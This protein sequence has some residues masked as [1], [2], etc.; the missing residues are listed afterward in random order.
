VFPKVRSTDHFWSARF[1]ILVRKKKP[2]YISQQKFFKRVLKSIF[3]THLII[4]VNLSLYY[5][6]AELCF[7]G[8]GVPQHFFRVFWSASSKSLGNT[9]LNKHVWRARIC[10]F[11]LYRADL[12]YIHKTVLKEGLPS[13]GKVC[14][15][16]H[17]FIYLQP[18]KRFFF[19][20][21]CQ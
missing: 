7:N 21:A 13:D 17:L 18:K 10:K 2:H 1:C 5:W 4:T 14:I 8:L 12:R 19:L 3:F 6:S 20:L 15:P 9:G 11:A 16:I